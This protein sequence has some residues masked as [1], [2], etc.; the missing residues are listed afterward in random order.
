VKDNNEAPTRSKRQ[1]T[2]KSFG[3]DFIIYLVDDTPSSISE[4]YASQDADYWKE[5]V[6]SEMDSILANGTW[7]ITD[8][9]YECKP[10]GYKWVFKKKLRPDS[11]IEKYKACLVAKGYTQKEGKDFFDTY[12]PVARL[13]TIRVLLSLATSHGLIIHQMDVNTAFLNG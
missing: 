5:A 11:T 7:E 3:N 10:V 8:R 1:R 13:T 6:R 12:S 9:S 4:V 2:A